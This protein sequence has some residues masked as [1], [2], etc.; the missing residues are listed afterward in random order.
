MKIKEPY[1]FLTK[2]NFLNIGFILLIVFVV[3]ILV[4]ILIMGFTKDGG[5]FVYLMNQVTP[6]LSVVII[7]MFIYSMATYKSMMSIGNQ[8]GRTRLS[9]MMAN[10]L[11]MI[12]L[13]LALALFAS[14]AGVSYITEGGIVLSR[15][16]GVVSN[17]NLF[18][19]EFFWIFTSLFNTYAVGTFISSI[20]NRVKP[21]IRLIIFVGIPV[22]MAML[23]PKIVMSMKMNDGIF[24]NFF[25]QIG[26]FFGYTESGINILQNTI[27]T[28]VIISLPLLLLSYLIARRS[29]LNDKKN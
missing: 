22:L 17:G 14:F 21:L 11:S 3:N 25:L 29:T 2:D 7:I 5:G 4:S 18:I 1:K 12:T 15:Y 28:T 8:F 10:T 19:K 9:M 20:W 23:I 27:T 13:I 6:N 26:K 24:I 16:K